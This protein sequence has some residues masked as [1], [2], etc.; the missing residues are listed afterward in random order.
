MLGLREEVHGDPVGVGVT[1][2]DDEDF[3][4]AGD[5]VDTD[6]AEDPALGSR[7]VGVAGADDLVHLRHAAGAVG[8]GSDC[9]GAAD[10]EHPIDPGERRGSEHQR[11]LFAGRR[12]HDHD[13]FADPSDPRRDRVHQHRRRVRR[14]ATGDVEADPVKRRHLLAEHGAADFVALFFVLPA[15]EG[16]PLVVAA[17]ALGSR[18]ERLSLGRWQCG[19]G[20]LQRVLRQLEFGHRIDA[21]AVEA[22]GVLDQR[23]V[24]ACFHR[25][26]DVGDRSLDGVVLGRFKGEQGVET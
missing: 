6:D 11:V 3:G 21:E 4:W 8:E 9:L 14:L 16:L 15:V 18:F 5:H 19:E 25:G 13:Q 10:G 22:A 24:A 23:R 20:L 12:R 1:V 2:T 7:N 26:D 17:D